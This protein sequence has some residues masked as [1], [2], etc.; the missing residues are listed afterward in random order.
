MHVECA[1]DIY[2]YKKLYALYESLLHNMKY[3]YIDITTT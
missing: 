2:A 1:V 3:S